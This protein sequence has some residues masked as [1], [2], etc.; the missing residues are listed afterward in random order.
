MMSQERAEFRPTNER[1]LAATA[2]P[3]HRHANRR[4]AEL[5]QTRPIVIDPVVLIVTTKL[6]IERLPDFFG[7]DRQVGSKPCLQ[8]PKF[9]T[10][11]LRRRFPLQL[12]LACAAVAAVMR[13]AKK[14]KR[15]RCAFQEV[16]K[17]SSA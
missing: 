16:C 1:L 12:E 5:H 11:L 2:Q 4:L 13:E 17:V 8:F 6:R 15:A 9:H 7:R 3:A 14:V 10:Q